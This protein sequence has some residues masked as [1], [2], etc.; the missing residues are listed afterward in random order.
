VAPVTAARIVGVLVGF[1]ACG[2]LGACRSSTDDGGSR[3]VIVTTYAG[4]RVLPGAT[5]IGHA[6]DGQVIDQ[7]TADA[8]GRAEVG[9]DDDSLV[10]VVFPAG[11]T[12][13]TPV[14]SIVTVPVPADGELAIHGPPRA[15]APPLIVGTLRVSAPSLPGATYFEIRIGCAAVRAAQLP[16]SVDVTACSMGSDSKLDVIVAGYHDVG[17]DP[18]APVLDGHAAGR[19]A[20]QNGSAALDLTA[21]ETAG[22]SVP[23]V[24]D[25]VTPGIEML[26]LADGLP[27]SSQ[28]LTDHGTL[29]TGLVVDATRLTAALP[30]DNAARV[31]HRELAGAPSTIAFAAADFL[32]PVATTAAIASLAPTTITWDATPIGDAVNLRATWQAGGRVVWD[33]VLP[34]DAS[35]A[36]LPA[37]DGALGDAI[38]PAMIVPVDVLVRHVDSTAHDGFAALLAAGVHAEETLQASTIAPRPAT[39]D[40]KISH[41]IGLR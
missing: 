23:V 6:P 38:A 40:I 12:A 11:A 19:I 16:A 35:S 8:V 3:T 39:G 27:M 1:G 18:P 5:V 36:T 13:L 30:G 22:P 31:T 29:W 7:T 4:D 10:S 41:A 32:P 20:M 2:L 26:L 33:A 24:L 14:I 28:Q 37:I 17:G 34:P 21:W 25:G 15:S 9:V